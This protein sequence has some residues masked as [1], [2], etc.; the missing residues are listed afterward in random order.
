VPTPG[1]EILNYAATDEPRS[2]PLWVRGVALAVSLAAAAVIFLP[3]TWD[4]SP[5]DVVGHW[6]WVWEDLKFTLLAIPFFLAFPMVW[7]RVRLLFPHAIRPAERIIIWTI[8]LLAVS[9]TIWVEGIFIP[10]ALR[11]RDWSEW[12]VG[13]PPIVLL[14]GATPTFVRRRRITPLNR[15]IAGLNTVYLGNA[16]MCVIGFAGAQ[17]FGWYMTIAVGSFMV[18]EFFWIILGLRRQ[19]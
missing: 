3:F 7:I 14:A 19:R 6:P 1:L 11:D 2:T 8:A 12:F 15:I 4:T 18:F 13:T 9:A 16:V 10:E 17:D 5:W